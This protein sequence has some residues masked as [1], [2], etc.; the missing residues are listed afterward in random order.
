[1]KNERYPISLFNAILNTEL[2]MKYTIP[3]IITEQKNELETDLNA[4]I[5]KSTPLSLRKEVISVALSLNKAYNI[6][7]Q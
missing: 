1:M 7:R 2:T 5:D 3:Q 6:T 4:V